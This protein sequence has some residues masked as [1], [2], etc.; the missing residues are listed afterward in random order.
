MRLRDRPTVEVSVVVPASPELV[1]ELI[2]DISL[3]TRFDGELQSAEWVEG[4]DGVAVG[5][6]FLGTNSSEHLGTWTTECEVVDVEPGRRWMWA[7]QGEAA[8]MAYWGFEVEPSSKGSIVRQFARVG[9]GE[10]GISGAIAANPEREARILD[11]RLGMWRTA[12][13]ANLD[14]LRSVIESS[15]PG[16]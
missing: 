3:P 1:W 10:S 4:F 11:H 12:M 14:G 16:E 5:A 9:E 15:S 13:Q 2:T 8:P 7:V 6:R